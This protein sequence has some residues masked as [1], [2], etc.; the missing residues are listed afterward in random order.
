MRTVVLY[1][2]LLYYEGILYSNLTF[3]SLLYRRY[4]WTKS[5]RY[6]W[7]VGLVCWN[8]HPSC[9]LGKLQHVSCREIS[10]RSRVSTSSE[11]FDL[12]T[13][14]QLTR[15]NVSQGSA[16]LLIT[17]LAYPQHRGKLTTMYNTL[18]YLGSIIAAWTIFG[19]IKYTS[20]AAWRIP[21]GMQAAMPLIQVLGIWF[22][23][24]SPRWLCAK[25]RPDEAFDV[26]V[27]V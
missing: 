12:A 18:W 20:E 5:R 25:D 24:E 21:V 16:P 1:V 17:E 9:S 15:S 19:T 3:D 13:D 2:T 11:Y 22:L 26:L 4:P 23:P 8:H 10:R 27:K 7:L 14:W 6:P